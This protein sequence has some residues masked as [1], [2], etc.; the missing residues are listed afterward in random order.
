MGIFR[1][2]GESPLSTGCCLR[3]PE[4][5]RNLC[6][7]GYAGNAGEEVISAALGP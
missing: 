7:E 6:G 4:G 1:L 2:G 3:E 5:K